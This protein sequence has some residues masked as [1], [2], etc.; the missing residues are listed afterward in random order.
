MAGRD[1]HHLSTGS[2]RRQY[3]FRKKKKRQKISEFRKGIIQLWNK[4]K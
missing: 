1:G 3:N 4:I 2:L